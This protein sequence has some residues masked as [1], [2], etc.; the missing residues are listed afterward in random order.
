MSGAVRFYLELAIQRAV[1]LVYAAIPRPRPDRQALIDCKIVAHRGV[2][3]NI[4]VKENTLAAFDAAVEIGVWGIEF[5]VRWTR[6]YEPVVIHDPGC[7]RVFGPDLV[8][9]D[10]DF[11]ELRQTI[12]QVP[13]L[14]EVVARYGGSTHMMIELK[15]DSLASIERKRDRLTAIFADLVP[16]RDFHFLALDL[17]L[18]APA[19]E[20]GERACIAVA[21]LNVGAL[22][23][24]TLCREIAGFSGQYVLLHAKLVERHRRRQQKIGTGFIDSRFCFYRELNRGIDWI[25]TNAAVKLCRLRQRLLD[26]N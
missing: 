15:R 3:D 19:D 13:S 17:E 16:A 24:A 23:R 10:T 26:G 1:D 5:D 8:I 9:A 22:S 7:R 14:A 20:I 2:F 21:E 12:P 11:A 6:D 25:F 4:E 18:F